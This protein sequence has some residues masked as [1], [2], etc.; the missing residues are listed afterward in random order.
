MLPH[1]AIRLFTGLS[2]LSA[3]PLVRH[4]PP[5]TSPVAVRLQ[6]VTVLLFARYVLGDGN[7]SSIYSNSVPTRG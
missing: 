1:L 3:K 5:R 7:I 2:A 6:Y 4:I